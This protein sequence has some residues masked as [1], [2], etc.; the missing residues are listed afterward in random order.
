MLNRILL[1]VAAM[2]TCPA[3]AV[4]HPHENDKTALKAELQEPG[5]AV[6]FQQPAPQVIYMQPPVEYRYEWH[7]PVTFRQ[8]AFFMPDSYMVRGRFPLV[9]PL[10]PLRRSQPVLFLR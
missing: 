3:A 6:R 7:S 8:P 4:A 5:P 1:V 10:L 9:R 2:V